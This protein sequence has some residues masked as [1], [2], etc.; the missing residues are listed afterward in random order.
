MAARS[1][2]A[3]SFL[4]YRVSH[5]RWAEAQ[6]EDPWIAPRFESITWITPQHRILDNQGSRPVVADEEDR[7]SPLSRMVALDPRTEDSERHLV[8]IVVDRCAGSPARRAALGRVGAPPSGLVVR[9]EAVDDGPR[10]ANG[11][12]PTGIGACVR[13]R[14]TATERRVDDVDGKAVVLA[15]DSHRRSA[16]IWTGWVAPVADEHRVHD[17]ESPTTDPHRTAAV[18]IES[19]RVAVGER[20]VLNGEAWMVLILAVWRRPHLGTIT[21]VHVQDSPCPGAGQRYEPTTVD[22]DLGSGVVEDPRRRA[23]DDRVWFG[24]AVESN[25]ASGCHRRNDGGRC[26]TGAGSIADHDVWA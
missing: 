7:S 13:E 15:E 5:L 2:E 21:R 6:V 3:A 24:T 19:H 11:A 16:D 20:Q 1:R 17:L 26:A 8:A 23:H 12:D 14:G 22:D 9:E 10:H 18:G 25:D 4:D